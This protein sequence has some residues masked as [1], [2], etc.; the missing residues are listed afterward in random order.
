MNRLGNSPKTVFPIY[1][2][3]Q[4]FR[5][6][7]IILFARSSAWDSFGNFIQACSRVWFFMHCYHLKV[8][9]SSPAREKKEQFCHILIFTTLKRKL[10]AQKVK[11][12]VHTVECREEVCSVSTTVWA[13]NIK[14]G[15]LQWSWSLWIWPRHYKLRMF[16]YMCEW[17]ACSV[18]VLPYFALSSQSL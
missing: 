13:W 1:T 10:L 4:I 14:V 8:I 17:Y 2:I 11:M 18:M 3:N 9:T 12:L 6:I 15:Y 7:L 16:L 5:F